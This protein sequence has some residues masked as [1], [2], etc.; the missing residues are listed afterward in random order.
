[1][2]VMSTSCKLLAKKVLY[3]LKMLWEQFL[4]PVVLPYLK[5]E[6]VSLNL[7]SFLF[8]ISP[9]PGGEAPS[10]PSPLP[11]NDT[12]VSYSK[13]KAHTDSV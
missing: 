11:S 4:L 7:L 12:A 5:K 1:M 2:C 10:C 6:F 8:Q 3:F 13:C 9:S